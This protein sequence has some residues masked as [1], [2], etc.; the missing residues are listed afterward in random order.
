M[1]RIIYND[2]A[3]ASVEMKAK[4]VLF[5]RS[6]VALSLAAALTACGG[7]GGASTTATTA[8]VATYSV[9]GTVS[10]LTSDG[11]EIANG[12]STLAIGS[13][14]SSFTF[15]TKVAQSGSYS[16]AVHTQPST[17]DQLCA[18]TSGSGTMGAANVTNVAVACRATAWSVSTLAGTF[19]GP[20]GM[21][22]DAGGNIYVAECN[23]NSI[24][25]IAFT[26]AV[27]TLGTGTAGFSDNN[28]GSLATFDCPMDVAVD[29]GGNLYVADAGN[30]I[31]RKITSAGAVSTFAGTGGGAGGSVDGNGTVASF[32]FP[33]GIAVDGYGTV[34]VADT[35]NNIIRKITSSRDVTTIAGTALVTGSNN[36]FGG[37]AEFNYPNGIAVDLSG[38]VYVADAN[39]HIIRQLSIAMGGAWD[40][41]TRAG[42]A[43]SSGSLDG[44]ILATFA[45][46]NHL[47]VDANSNIYVSD[48]GGNNTIRKISSSGVVTTLAGTAGTSGSLDAIGST[49]SFNS[50]QGIA[51]DVNGNLYIAD[52]TN[53]KIRK[54]IA[55]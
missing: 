36:G 31:I 29:A 27:T 20:S 33:A 39:N 14:A 40:V 1:N 12:L 41:T 15:A 7:G 23:S 42:T 11:L 6:C 49:A 46:P 25:K 10:G 16:V 47:A 4:A 18:V 19:N 32:N 38:N 13:G 53:N 34:Y 9:G 2:P 50:P 24:R 52:Y 44:T 51:V 22:V 54:I 26:G 17:R 35:L 55:Q 3:H 45:T 30:N 28:D 8:S 43:G 21:A 5:A 48:G 37:A